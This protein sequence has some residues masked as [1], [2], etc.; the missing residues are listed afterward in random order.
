MQSVLEFEV[1]L[2]T[3]DRKNLHS[4]SDGGNG[5]EYDLRRISELGLTVTDGSWNG[6][7]EGK[8]RR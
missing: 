7:A 4:G 3:G 1:G 2:W 8:G 6:V 5:K